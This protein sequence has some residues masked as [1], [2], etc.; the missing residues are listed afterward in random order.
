M[1]GVTL[2]IGL[3]LPWFAGIAVVVALTGRRAPSAPGE[4][5]WIAGSGYL[6]GAFLLTLWMRALSFAGIAF[7]W[8]A[9]ATPL[10]ML[11]AGVAAIVW[12]REASAWREAFRDATRAVASPPGVVGVARYAWWALL[13]WI[14]LRFLL[15]ALDVAWQPLYPWNAWTQ[16]ATKARVWFELSRIVPFAGTES[17]FAADG[18]A[19][20]DAAP[21]VPPTVPLLQVWASI[22][23]GRWDDA[24]MNWPWWQIA[25]AL[26]LAVYG[27]MRTLG[28]HALAAL[29]AAFLVASLPLANVHVAL[30]GYADLPLAACYTCAVL[31]LLRFAA[32]RNPRDAAL[33]A[34]LAL[35]CTQIRTPGLGWAMTLVPGLIAT[36]LPGRGVKAGLSLLAAI[37]FVIVV[38]AQSNPSLLG[39]SLHLAFDPNWPSLAE[40]YFLLGSWN[41]L[42][43]AALGVAL[44]AWRDLASPALAPL[45]LVVAAATTLLFVLVAFPNARADLADQT[46]VN[47]ATLQIAPLVA[48]FVALAFRAFADR[49]AATG[50][51][52]A[53]P[54]A[55]PDSTASHAD[56]A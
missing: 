13:A 30:A 10:A 14:A 44:L 40:S 39:H 53:Q 19:Y 46:S 4:L 1:A 47:R 9:I 28:M 48:V 42:W 24:L 25:A 2:T 15:L 5:A 34:V 49:L 32:I 22:A 43:Y 54:M 41:L 26:A 37:W 20:F 29:A 18:A 7:G 23:L 8:F 38:L 33:V 16:W 55:N 50:A 31:A 6:L 21:G 51:A 17:W 11:A 56:A 35:A 52:P 12:R 27:A 3:L 36:L 45:T